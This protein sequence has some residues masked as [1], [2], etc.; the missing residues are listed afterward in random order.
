MVYPLFSKLFI[1]NRDTSIV[2]FTLQDASSFK[3]PGEWEGEYENVGKAVEPAM[4]SNPL[5]YHIIVCKQ[6][7]IENGNECEVIFQ[8]PSSWLDWEQKRFVYPAPGYNVNGLDPWNWRDMNYRRRRYPESSWVEYEVSQYITTHPGMRNNL[9]INI[10]KGCS[11]SMCVPCVSHYVVHL[12]L[13]SF[14]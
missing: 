2:L 9:I 10:Y 5:S 12:G 6:P 7:D 11:V 3:G 13:L 4:A 1:L 8:V 14:K